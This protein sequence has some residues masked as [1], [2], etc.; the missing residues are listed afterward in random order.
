MMYVQLVDGYGWG[1]FKRVYEEYRDLPA[2]FRPKSD[3]DKRD[4]WLVRFSRSVGRDLI[5]FFR[6]LG[7]S[8]S[9][10]AVRE[11]SGL[12]EWIHPDIRSAKTLRSE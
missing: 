3:A 2:Q 6:A 10:A 12:P 9:D 8:V 1:A 7:V 5:P 4:H 11:V